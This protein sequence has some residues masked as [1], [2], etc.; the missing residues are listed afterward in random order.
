MGLM[1]ITHDLAV[2]AGMADQVAVMRDGP[3]RRGRT[4]PRRSS[5]TRGHPYTRK[6]F[7]ASAACARAGG[8]ARRT[9]VLL[10]VEARHAELSAAAPVAVRARGRASR[11]WTG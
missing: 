11:R 4:G 9:R 5:A 7:A 2:V 6:L 10:S 3:G 8:D 1:L